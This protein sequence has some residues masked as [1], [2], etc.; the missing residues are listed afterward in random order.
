MG[1]CSR[2]LK[3][4]PQDLANSSSAGDRHYTDLAEKLEERVSEAVTPSLVSKLVNITTQKNKQAHLSLFP[5]TFLYSFKDAGLWLSL[6]FF[7]ASERSTHVRYDLFKCAPKM[8]TDEEALARAIEGPMQDLVK[9]IEGEYRSVAGEP[10]DLSAG[11]RE[12]LGCVQ[13][14]AKLER[15]Q[16]GLILPAMHQ[17]KGSSLFQQAEQRM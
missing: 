14:H 1:V 12:I 4:K 3:I 7:P 16:G 13:E 8:T 17:P 2:D 5:G 10:T 11:M 15:A 9:A 6:S